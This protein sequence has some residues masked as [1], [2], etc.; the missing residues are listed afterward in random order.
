MSKNLPAIPAPGSEIDKYEWFQGI[1]D[2]LDNAQLAEYAIKAK[3][4]AEVARKAR[5]R[6]EH[7]EYQRIYLRALVEVADTPPPGA[8]GD[9]SRPN[10]RGHS[11]LPATDLKRAREARWPDGEDQLD[12]CIEQ[13]ESMPEPRLRA[14]VRNVRSQHTPVDL[15]TL[16]AFDLI[17][18]DPPWTYTENVADP[19]RTLDQ[20]YPTMTLEDIKRLQPPAADDA[21]LLLW[22][23][24]P[25]LRQQLEVIAEWGFTYKT[26]AV[27][28]KDRAGM[29]YWFRQQHE[30]LLLGTKGQ[31]G[32]PEPA[33]RPSSVMEA[34]RGEHSSKPDD[35]YKTIESMFPHLTRRLEM[36]ARRQREGWLVWGNDAE[37]QE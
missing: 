2:S 17:L 11:V 1:V 31:P 15:G 4:W 18:A 7:V 37:V 36:F 9:Q 35:I 3:A 25:L 12:S 30:F 6:R 5:A 19:T 8:G 28:V 26:C 32:T 29:G 24:S 22:A 21:V 14:L 16:K 23:T 13:I 33:Q 27:W 20:H 34:P 10:G